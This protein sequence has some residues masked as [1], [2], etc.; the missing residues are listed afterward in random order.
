MKKHI[1]LLE[2]ENYLY[3]K[4]IEKLEASEKEIESKTPHLNTE[5]FEEYMKKARVV[6]CSS[7]SEEEPEDTGEYEPV[8]AVD[9][10]R[11]SQDS[12][13]ENMS[14]NSKDQAI[15]FFRSVEDMAPANYDVMRHK[16]LIFIICIPNSPF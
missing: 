10:I 15:A 5:E 16:V 12:F 4:T 6:I 11:M 2:T 3:E 1:L 7:E 8:H 14:D 13:F 9:E